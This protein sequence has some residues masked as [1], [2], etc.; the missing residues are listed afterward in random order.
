MGWETDT[1]ML[2][3]Y[4]WRISTEK[5]ADWDGV[6]LILRHDKAGLYA[7]SNRISY[8][9]IEH[10]FEDYNRS[11]LANVPTPF[12][13]EGFAREINIHSADPNMFHGYNEVNTIPEVTNEIKSIHEFGLF[14]AIPTQEEVEGMIFAESDIPEVLSRI[15]E[16]QKPRQIEILRESMKKEYKVDANPPLVYHSNI[17]GIK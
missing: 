17:I 13:I 14:D 9:D 8:R 10:A 6:Q 11:R 12:H 2:G 4:G 16:L 15:R 3:Q 5:R 1:Y 7:M